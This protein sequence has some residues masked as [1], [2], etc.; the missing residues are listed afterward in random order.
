MA[1]QK[2]TDTDDSASSAAYHHGNLREALLQACLSALDVPD[3]TLS[4]ISMRDMARQVGVSANA[5]YRHFA[6]KEDLLQAAAAEGFRRLAKSSALALSSQSDA[7]MGFRAT[8]LAYVRF[9]RQHP[10]L[11]RL[12]FACPPEQA[13]N[14]D[15]STAA[16]LAFEA[17]KAS[18]AQVAGLQPDHP[19]AM[20]AALR[21]WT[22]AHGLAHLSLDRQ[23]DRLTSDVEALVA[24]VLDQFEL[25]ATPTTP[26][27]GLLIKPA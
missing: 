1:R 23:L 24:A 15:L 21:A 19:A 10:L 5:A 4:S 2:N 26:P 9:A 11:F 18:A 25:A 16:T 20:L 12:M 13:Q 7:F 27:E 6:G 14:P 3:A 17:M 8:G 22:V